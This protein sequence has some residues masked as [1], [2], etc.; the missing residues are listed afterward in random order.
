MKFYRYF[1]AVCIV[2]S[3]FISCSKTKDVPAPSSDNSFSSF[4]FSV[5]VN[6]S[7]PQDIRCTISNDTIYAITF[8]GT[9]ITALK[10]SF[11]TNDATVAVNGQ[12]QVSSQS[13]LNFTTPVK[14]TVTAD[15]GTSKAYVVSFSDT[16]LPVVY[17]STNNV[18]IESKEVYVPGYMQIKQH[19]TGDSLYGGALEIRGRGNSTWN[20]PKKPYRI[21]LASKAALLGM[22][23]SKNWVLLA[24]YADK[25][26]I[27]NEVGFE[28]SR[29]IGLAYTPSGRFVD[30]ILNGKYIGNYQLV[31]QI[32]V[33][34]DKVNVAEQDEDATTLPQIS[35]GYLVEVD[36]FAYSE[37]VFFITS[38]GMAISVH[39]PDDDDINSAQVNYITQHFA[40]FEDSLFAP[41]FSGTGNGYKQY[42]DLDSYVNWYLV[43]EIIGNPDI[44]WSTYMYKDYNDDKIYTGPVWDLDIAA[45]NDERIGD[46]ENKLMLDAAHEPKLWINRLMQDKAFRNAVR[47]RWN[48]IKNDQVNTI[49]LFT[50]EL[51]RQLEYSQQKNFQQWNILSEKVY[52]NLQVAGSYAGEINYLKNYL[53]NRIAWLDTEFNSGR[54]D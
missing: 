46:T 40:M 38:R 39:Y 8:S 35:G 24:S 11:V 41:S 29:R 20:M 26:L 48:T 23:G 25:S 42:F 52:L 9:D 16:R 18:P 30:V 36:G 47:D 54:F 34:E 43:N 49:P 37:D 10:A 44:F 14:Y 28:L 1:S 6:P 3:V 17:I 13:V 12:K 2:V 7:L 19:L 50:E 31:E 4:S 27:R 21:K 33:D 45:N 22:P 51:A 15:N 32:D 5:S 53:A